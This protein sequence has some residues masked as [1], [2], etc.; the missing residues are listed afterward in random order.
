MI[1]TK[2]QDPLIFQKQNYINT[3]CDTNFCICFDKDG[4][5]TNVL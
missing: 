4:G 3:S 5:T 2:G 1:N